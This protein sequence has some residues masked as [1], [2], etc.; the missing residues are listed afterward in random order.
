MKLVS[1][2]EAFCYDVTMKTFVILIRGINV[3]GKNKVSMTE[4]KEHLTVIGYV[5]VSTYINSG[6]VIL[7]SSKNAREIQI[8]I[9]ELLPNKF[10]LD[11]DLIKVLVLSDTTLTSIIEDRPRGFGSQP[12]KYHS[13]VIFLMNID[14]NEAFGVFSPKEGVDQIWQGKGAIYS[15]R[16]STERTKSRL[17]RIMSSPHY[18]SMAI[19]NW[20]TTKKLFEMLRKD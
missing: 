7:K 12:E 3:G 5:N 2:L 20:N 8:E 13:D 16:L 19:R 15:Q 11:S 17:N 4:L 6:N 1:V 18:K 10:K 9:E 14:Q